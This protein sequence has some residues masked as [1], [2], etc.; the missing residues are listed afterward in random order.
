MSGLDPAT[1]LRLRRVAWAQVEVITP[2]SPRSPFSI[3]SEALNSFELDTS[4]V[5]SRVWVPFTG[6]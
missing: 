5:V 3:V 6:N 4:A 2:P 1:S